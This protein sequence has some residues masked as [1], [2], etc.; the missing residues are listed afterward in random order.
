MSVIGNAVDCSHPTTL[1]CIRGTLPVIWRYVRRRYRTAS[2]QWFPSGKR[3]NTRCRSRGRWLWRVWTRLAELCERGGTAQGRG[4]TSSSTTAP[5][6]M[7]RCLSSSVEGNGYLEWCQE[8]RRCWWLFIPRHLAFRCIH[9]LRLRLSEDSSLMWTSSSQIRTLSITQ[10]S[11]AGN[12][13]TW[14]SN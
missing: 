12:R 11:R 14:S 9:R 8:V 7:T 6:R 5:V 1:E 10:E 13:G 3:V 2:M 4:I